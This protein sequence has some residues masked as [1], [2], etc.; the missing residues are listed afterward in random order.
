[1]QTGFFMPHPN[2]SPKERGLKLFFFKFYIEVLSFGE[3]FR[4]RQ[5]IFYICPM[6][7]EQIQDLRDRLISL[8]RHL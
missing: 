8:R 5:L 1:M 2:P 6:T 7:K 4:V 3:R